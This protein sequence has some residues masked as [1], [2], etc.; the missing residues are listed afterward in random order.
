MA[1]LKVLMM[2][3]RRCGKTSALA[4]L[5]DQMKN[6]PEINKLLTVS[7]KTILE[8]KYIDGIAEKQEALNNKK[9]ELQSFLKKYHS[10]DFL[11]DKGPTINF[12]L[13]NMQILLAGTSK[14]M[15]MEFCDSAGEFFDHGGVHTQE[16]MQYVK[17]C[18]VYVIVVDTPYLMCDDDAVVAAANVTDSIHTFLTSIDEN[19]DNKQ[20][21]KCVLFVPIKCEKW[22]HEGK[23]QEV[24]E[25]IKTVYGASINHLQ[26]RSHTEIAIIPIQTAGDIEFSEMRDPYIVVDAIGNVKKCSKVT[27]HTVVLSDGCMY[28]LKSTDQLNP[29]PEG[30]F[31]FDE[32]SLDIVR[33]SLWF[34]H[35]SKAPKYSPHNCEQIALHILRF[36]LNKA[37]KNQSNNR[38]IQ[39]FR[40]IFGA[41]TVN[42]LNNTI[43]ELTNRSLIKD[44]GEGIERIKTY[45]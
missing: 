37:R 38:F 43:I 27:D 17:D 22:L 12:W 6:T 42:D 29:D 25:K 34:H 31:K 20:E 2:G 9:L 32:D 45:S 1:N 33:P 4:S 5:F 19:T 7:D 10:S 3:G 11:I 41:I 24:N 13:Y 35:S 26:H 14:A 8:T 16:T 40:A 44:I 39:F 18:D 15:T 36:M 28:Q 21:A 30:L 23:I